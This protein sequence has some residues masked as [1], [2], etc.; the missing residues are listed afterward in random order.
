MYKFFMVVKKNKKKL[1]FWHWQHEAFLHH[2]HASPNY[3]SSA[4][5]VCFQHTYL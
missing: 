5:L 2:Q 4:S 3:F 1:T